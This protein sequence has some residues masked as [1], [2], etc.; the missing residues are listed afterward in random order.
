MAPETPSP[1][2]RPPLSGVPDVSQLAE[3]WDELVSAMRAKGNN[4]AAT[5]LEHSSAVT[6]NA[7][8]DVTIAL[9]DANPSLNPTLE[10][11]AVKATLPAFF[12][13]GGKPFGWQSQPQWNAYGRWMTDHHLIAGPQAW[14]AASTNQLLAGQ[15]P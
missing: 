8:R 12:P 2:R 6:V 10:T 1:V 4:L 11:A 9:D 14:A 7:K 3:R 15:G 5:A 13:T